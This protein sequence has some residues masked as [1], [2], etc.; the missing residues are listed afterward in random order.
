M[1]WWA[2]GEVTYARPMR[3]WL[4][5][6]ALLFYSYA[7]VGHPSRDY[8]WVL[9]RTPTMTEATY[10]SIVERLQTQGYETGRLVRTL[11]PPH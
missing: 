3:H 4:S 7:V 5:V 1:S 10:Q 2:A 9:S 11:Q 6:C 8:L